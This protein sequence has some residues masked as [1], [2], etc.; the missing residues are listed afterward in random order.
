VANDA[1]AKLD[2]PFAQAYLEGVDIV[3]RLVRMRLPEGMLEINAPL[4]TEEKEQQGQ[5]KRHGKHC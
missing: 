2:L 3:R 5:R 1:G 4:T